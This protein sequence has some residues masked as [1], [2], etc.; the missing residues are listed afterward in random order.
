MGRHKSITSTFNRS[1][2]LRKNDK[3]DENAKHS[4]NAKG[5][6]G[7]N[8][9]YV[10]ADDTT[11]DLVFVHGLGGGSRSTWTKNGE[12]SLYWPQEW[13]P[14]DPG[15]RDVSIHSFGYNSNWEKESSLNTY[16]FSKSLLES[17]HDCP[18]VPRTKNVRILLFII[19]FLVKR[20]PRSKKNP[21]ELF[22]LAH[23]FLQQLVPW[24]P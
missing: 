1:I 19:K 15:F 13:L 12:S 16:D 20:Y 9:L 22:E 11:A 17:I 7:L 23:R 24:R 2:F 3:Y 21:K 14:N 18:L 8:T 4:K 10:P 6:L 5:P